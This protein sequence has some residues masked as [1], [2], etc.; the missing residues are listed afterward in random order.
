MTNARRV[1]GDVDGAIAAGQEALAL[2]AALGDRA[3]HVQAAHRLGQAYYAIGDFGRA[4]ELLRRNVEA[5]DRESGT[6]STDALIESQAWLAQTLTALGAFA[7]GRRHGEEALRLATREGRGA[8]PIIAHGCLGLLYL[9]Q[10][11]LEHAIRVLEPGLALCRASGYRPWVQ[12]ILV[13]LGSAAVLQGRMAEGRALV[14]EAINEAFRTGTLRGLAG[15]VAWL[16]EIC[17]LAGR[18]EDA[19]QHALQALDW[20]RRQKARGNE[21]HAL[22]EIGVLHAHADPS[23]VVQAEAHYQQA[24][25]LAEALGM[26]PLMAHCYLG[27]GTLYAKTQQREQAHTELSAAIALYRAMEMAFWLPEAE[28]ALAQVEER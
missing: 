26:R 7:E 20:A 3:L 18:S 15:R 11:D 4:A 16:S 17:R 24:L 25:A 5:A 27:L 21:A 9:A 28:A 22:Y 1:T 14:E 6:A 13:G 8:T 23:D 19:W 10:G 2:A 12:N